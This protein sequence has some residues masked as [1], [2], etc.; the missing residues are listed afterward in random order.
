MAHTHA[1]FNARTNLY[2]QA[3]SLLHTLTRTDTHKQSGCI[4]Q[5]QLFIMCLIFSLRLSTPLSSLHTSP[6]LSSKHTHTHTHSTTKQLNDSKEYSNVTRRRARGWGTSGQM[7]VSCA[8]A[9]VIKR[10]REREPK[11]EWEKETHT[12]KDTEL[13]VGTHGA[14]PPPQRQFGSELIGREQQCGSEAALPSESKRRRRTINGGD[15]TAR[16]QFKW[17]ATPEERSGVGR[18][19]WSTLQTEKEDKKAKPTR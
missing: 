2:P 19:R 4:F 18:P 3:P 17:L 8:T 7:F 16:R 10:A 13:R 5:K 1:D 12:H 9:C 6:P 14:P 11:R 15:E